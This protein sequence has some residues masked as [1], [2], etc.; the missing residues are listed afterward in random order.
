MSLQNFKKLMEIREKFPE[1]TF[2]NQGY[3]YIKPE[4]LEKHSEQIKE[5]EAILDGE[6]KGIV[7]FNNF[8]PSNDGE[9]SIRCQAKYDQSFTG[10][11]YLKEKDFEDTEIVQIL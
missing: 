8:F 9:F 4:V 5:I 6:F 1:L 10:V 11:V 2:K 3:Q 7:C